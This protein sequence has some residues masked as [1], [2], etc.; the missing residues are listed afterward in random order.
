M[1][2]FLLWL[3]LLTDQNQTLLLFFTFS[4]FFFIGCLK[5]KVNFSIDKIFLTFSLV[6]TYLLNFLI[7]S[8]SLS[9]L[10]FFLF[11]LYLFE[12]NFKEGYKL[13]VSPI[14]L[15]YFIVLFQFLTFFNII[16]HDFLNKI[17]GDGVEVYN[18][19]MENL[20]NVRSMG[21][22]GNP[23]YAAII[24]IILYFL[25]LEIKNHSKILLFFVVFCGIV[26]TGSRAALLSLTIIIFFQFIKN[27]K[28]NLDKIINLFVAGSLI[29]TANY[30][31][32]RILRFENITNDLS[33]TARTNNLEIYISSLYQNGDFLQ[34]L[35]GNGLRD[36]YFYF[37]DGDI[38]NLFYS[39]GAIG[40]L[41]FFIVIFIKLK[42][43]NSHHIFY[44]LLPIFFAGGIF[45][46][47]K[48]LYFFIF[49]PAIIKFLRNFKG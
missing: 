9:F 42:K 48:T 40:M 35:F 22:F 17:I 12:F 4:S 14:S 28:L 32:L 27:K 16:E 49:L 29:F 41:L 31:D 10:Y 13:L 3:V 39:L 1:F 47:Y 7:I 24:L 11:I 38:G 21:I 44:S 15:I 37:F 33:F 23:N 36:P 34:F 26:T 25:S 46:N 8:S 5:M 43:I 18:Y 20:E 2:L 45:G 19:T 6:C 30:F